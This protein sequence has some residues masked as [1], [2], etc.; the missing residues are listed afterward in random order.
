MKA[1]RQSLIDRMQKKNIAI[2]EYCGA[3]KEG[4]S[5]C[6]GA[7]LEPEWTMIEGTGKMACPNCWK[8]ATAEGKA[9]IDSLR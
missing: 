3:K 7:S 1:K 5:F 6:I 2:C 4:L 8:K 9:V